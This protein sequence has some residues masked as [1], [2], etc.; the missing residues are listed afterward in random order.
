MNTIIAPEH[1]HL[2]FAYLDS[3]HSADLRDA[4]LI[5]P[6]RLR[7][8]FFLSKLGGEAQ[9][10][11]THDLL[12]EWLAVLEAKMD[13]KLRCHSPFYWIYLY[14]RIRPALHP[15]SFEQDRRGD[16]IFGPRDCRARHAEVR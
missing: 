13:E 12:R 4:L 8:E 5:N 1:H 6:E 15:G 16:R 14:R 2:V 3:R 7:A 9:V 10:V 11:I